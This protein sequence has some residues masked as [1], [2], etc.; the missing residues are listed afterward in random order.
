MRPCGTRRPSPS[1]GQR[2]CLV[3]TAAARPTRTS[4]GC[5]PP[6]GNSTKRPGR[7]GVA[8]LDLL[9]DGQAERLHKAG[10]HR[11]RPRPERSRTNVR[12]HLHHPFVRRPRQHRCK[13]QASGPVP[14]LGLIAGSARPTR[15]GGHRIA[16]RGL[17]PDSVPVDFLHPVRGHPAGP[18][19]DPAPSAACAS[20]PWS[21]SARTPRSGWRRPEIHLRSLAAAGAPRRRL[22]LPRR[23]PD[24][25]GP[26]RARD[27]EMIADARLHRE[28]RGQRPCPRARRD[29]VRPA[30]A[31]RGPRCPRSPD[32]RRSTPSESYQRHGPADDRGG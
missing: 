25:R 21:A 30:A 9:A 31:A 4:P 18:R 26:A 19:V 20:W 24:Q 23:L 15:T 12:R 8:C 2:V 22:D 28:G 11:L 17:D 14:V 6:S 5:R 29:L 32:P 13:S 27:L 16:L 10:T 7:R 3:A 1:R